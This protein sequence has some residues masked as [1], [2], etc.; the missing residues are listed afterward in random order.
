MFSTSAYVGLNACPDLTTIEQ[1]TFASC[2][3]IQTYFFNKPID[4]QLIPAIIQT[5]CILIPTLLSIGRQELS[6]FDANYA[7]MVTASPFMIYVVFSSIRDILGFETG[8]FKRIKSHRRAVHFSVFLF[9]ALWF[10]LR[11]TLRLSSKAFRDSE[12][13]SN[14]TFKDLLI[15]FLLLFVPIAGPTGGYWLAVI[16]SLLNLPLDIIIWW[17]EVVIRFLARRE[18]ALGPQ[19][20]LSRMWVNMKGGWC[21]SITTDTWST[22]FD[23]V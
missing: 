21:V 8:L 16:G 23:A 19:E 1:L 22:E 17:C 6:I 12:L 13:C 15:D 7:L 3:G 2:P 11:L 5:Y 14:P 20:R 4:E 18:G 10:G 9:L